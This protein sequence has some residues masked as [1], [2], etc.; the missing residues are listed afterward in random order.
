MTADCAPPVDGIRGVVFDVDGT[1]YHQ[2]PL[3][4]LMVARILATLA[5][6]PRRTRRDIAIIKHYRR[7]QEVLREHPDRMPDLPDRQFR[8]AAETSGLPLGEIVD[9]ASF[10]LDV[11]PLAFLPLCARR[12]VLARIRRWHLRGVPIGVYSDYLAADKV[13]RLGLPIEPERCVASPD[14]DVCALKPAPGGFLA[15]AARLGL[16]AEQVA[17]VGDR[18]EVDARGARSAGMAIAL[19]D[20]GRAKGRP[21]EEQPTLTLETLEAHLARVY[22]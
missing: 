9:R 2:K 6:K 17:Y 21:E 1:L 16:E 20:P 3:R 15:A 7:A 13:A 22:K 11:A 19:V 5:I 14:P 18:P 12:D 8:L 4:Y 10:W